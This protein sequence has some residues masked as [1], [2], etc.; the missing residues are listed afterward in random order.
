MP[1]PCLGCPPG[2]LRGLWGPDV[3][4]QGGYF[5]GYF[6]GCQAGHHC[7]PRRIKGAVFPKPFPKGKWAP[8]LW[9]WPHR[10]RWDW[11]GSHPH[12]APGVIRG[13]LRWGMAVGVE[14]A[15]P[16]RARGSDGGA[17]VESCGS[18]LV[19]RGVRSCWLLL[20]PPSLHPFSVVLPAQDVPASLSLAS[21]QPFP[22]LP[23]PGLQP[24][25]LMPWEQLLQSPRAR[26]T[27]PGP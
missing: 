3:G 4:G 21:C 17:R 13:L 14:V 24:W 23:N 6:A 27:E 20:L 12:L 9:R 5:G 1:S 2:G 26:E 10:A 8:L 19:S 18:T 15:E 16:W 22:T 11:A 25:L 7:P